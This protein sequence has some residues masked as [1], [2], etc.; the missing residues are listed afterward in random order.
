MS[1]K[2]IDLF[3]GCGGLSLGL[4][5]AGHTGVLAVEKTGHAFSTLRKNLLEGARERFRFDWPAS[6][7]RQNH[8]IIELLANHEDA[9]LSLRGQVDLI[10]GGPPCQGFS[11]YGDRKPN[12]LRNALYKK[13]LKVVEL[14]QPRVVLL[15]NVEG[16]DMP[17]VQKRANSPPK[18]VHTTAARIKKELKAMGYGSVAFKLCSSE[19]GVPQVRPRFFIMA[20]RG[21]TKRTLQLATNPEFLESERIDHMWALRLD[22]A[23]VTTVRQAIS[24]LEITG[25]ARLPCQDTKGFQQAAYAG[26]LTPYQVSM[27]EGMTRL[28]APNSMRLPRHGDE[29]ITKFKLLQEKGQPG[30]KIGDELRK[31]LGTSKFRIHWLNADKLAP[32]ITTLPDD[33]IHYNEPRILTVREFAR[34]Q[35]FPDW[36]EFHGKY[37]TGGELRK[38]DCPRY[39]QI[40]NAVP[41]R[42]AMFLGRYLASLVEQD[43]QFK[44]EEEA[45]QSQPMAA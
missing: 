8:D 26:P 10:A 12:D 27:R 24:D 28:Q 14:V 32:T 38:V 17:F 9:L 33:F 20:M 45:D 25:K 3:A 2:F 16:I 23:A 22:P 41:P 18:V 1:L 5:Q 35:S 42:L 15:E 19:Y 43:D 31:E 30:Y 4:M 13:Y 39:S 6:I 21:A 36:F 37:T 29:T 44:A 11:V 34:L 40:G 7:P